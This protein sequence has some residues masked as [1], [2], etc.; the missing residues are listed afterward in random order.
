MTRYVVKAVI[1]DGAR[2][3]LGDDFHDASTLGDPTYKDIPD[4]AKITSITQDRSQSGVEFTISLSSMH[5]VRVA[6]EKYH[7]VVEKIPS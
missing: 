5:I 1:V 4:N 6:G 3:I 7:V 2:Y